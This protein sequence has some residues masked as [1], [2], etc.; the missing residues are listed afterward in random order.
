[1]KRGAPGI[2]LRATLL[3]GILILPACGIQ[4]MPIPPERV[5]PET[6]PPNPAATVSPSG[7][8]QT[9]GRPS[10]GNQ[11]GEKGGAEGP[12]SSQGGSGEVPEGGF[13]DEGGGP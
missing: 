4:G 5:P 8:N 3:S 12:S 9:G 13:P 2:L 10:S 1:M 6:A 7:K 11:E